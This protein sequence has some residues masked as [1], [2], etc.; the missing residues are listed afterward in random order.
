[1]NRWFVRTAKRQS[2]SNEYS[3][4]CLTVALSRYVESVGTFVK[5]RLCV[6]ASGGQTDGRQADPRDLYRVPNMD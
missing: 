6:V 1:M 2:K 5:P 3:L 4:P